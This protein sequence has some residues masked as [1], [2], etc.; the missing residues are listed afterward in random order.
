MP[1]LEIPG[2]RPTP[3]ARKPCRN[4]P[5]LAWPFKDAMRSAVEPLFWAE[6]FGV[7]C[8]LNHEPWIVLEEARLA[9]FT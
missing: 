2:P 9:G 3:Q 5:S 4:S 6:T 1:L 7:R 8:L